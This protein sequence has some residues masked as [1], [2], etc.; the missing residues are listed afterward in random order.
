MIRI[1]LKTIRFWRRNGLMLTFR[2][3]V[4]LLSKDH[5]YTFSE[6]Y[7]NNFW[8]N[9]ESASGSGSSELATREIRAQLPV[10]FS[11]W[12]FKNI[13][14]APCGDFNWM[15][16]V[17]F[18]NDMRYTGIDIVPKLISANNAK[19]SS[20]HHRFILADLVTDKIPE[21]DIVICRDC[22]FHLS[23]DDVLSFLK[24]FVASGTEFLL[25]TTHKNEDGFLNTDILTGEF[26][27]IDLFSSPFSLP[28]DVFYRFDDFIAPYPPREMCLW[29]RAQIMK[30]LSIGADSELATPIRRFAD[31]TA[32]V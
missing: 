11:K 13:I 15:K 4:S 7:N 30:A 6:I 32:F 5:K 31:E 26:R 28:K 22:L 17:N 19:Y 12:N 16:L 27:L 2:R 9:S 10:I 8:E 21:G 1:F 3:A 25:T 29:N 14:D 18:D 24:N 20:I 23:Y